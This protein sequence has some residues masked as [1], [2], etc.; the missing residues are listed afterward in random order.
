MNSLF[1]KYLIVFIVSIAMSSL[2]AQEIPSSKIGVVVMHGKGGSPTKFVA[3]MAGLLQEKG[4]LI[5]NLE[6][7]WSKKRDYDVDATMALKEVEKALE[8]LRS[9]GAEKLFVAGHSQ[10]GL[11]ALCVGGYLVADG[12]IAI[13]PGGNV[14]NATFRE[15]LGNYVE[16]AR[17]LIEKG[18]GDEKTTLFDFE[19]AKGTYPIVTTPRI[20]LG[21]FDPEGMMNQE[22]A[23]KKLNPKNPVLFIVPQHDY[24]GLLKVKQS[25]FSELPK[26]PYTKLYEPN[27]DHIGAP[28]ASTDEIVA[29]IDR[30]V[31]TK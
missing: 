17:S 12:I 15:K 1:K 24:P 25:M 20:Y 18:K 19:N 8:D 9:K 7:P 27:T 13:A 10:G 21:W 6:M 23:I 31:N 14:G 28:S 5:A 29:W 30:I 22:K 2:L 4:Y 16:E 11:F 3:Q 26:H